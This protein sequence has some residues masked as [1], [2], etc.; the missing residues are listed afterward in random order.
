[1]NWKRSLMSSSQLNFKKLWYRFLLK[2]QNASVRHT[3]KSRNAHFITGITITSCHWSPKMP[4]SFYQSCSQH[5]TTTQ[6]HI[7]IKP[8]MV[9]STMLSNSSWKWIINCLMS[10]TLNSVMNDNCKNSQLIFFVTFSYSNIFIF[11]LEKVNS[12][13][14][15][16]KSGNR[17]KTW[18]EK[19]I[20]TLRSSLMAWI[21]CLWKAIMALTIT[22]T[23]WTKT[24][25]RM[26]NTIN[27]QKM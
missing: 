9:S 16:R 27:I 15:V 3:F 22:M 14:S 24:T 5:S 4:P 13:K 20:P 6:R 7:G 11:T 26:S 10:A 17:L 12:I 2:S 19:I 18:R 25:T 1:M 8:F 23:S 21:T